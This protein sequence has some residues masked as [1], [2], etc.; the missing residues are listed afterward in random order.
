MV[1]R[2]K[3]HHFSVLAVL[4]LTE[5]PLF[6]YTIGEFQCQNCGSTFYKRR[7]PRGKSSGLR[8]EKIANCSSFNAM[9]FYGHWGERSTISLSLMLNLTTLRLSQRCRWLTRLRNGCT[10][11]RKTPRNYKGN[12]SICA[13]SS[14]PIC[15]CRVQ[16]RGLSWLVDN[17][18]L[19]N[20][21]KQ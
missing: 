18:S 1:W 10:Q 4:K 16:C 12:W 9:S 20:T 21:P 3:K 5:C 2:S 11:L 6:R 19:W 8:G 17:W 7:K 13:L 15:Q 14:W